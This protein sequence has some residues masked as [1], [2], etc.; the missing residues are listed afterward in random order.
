MNT[1]K[2]LNRAIDDIFESATQYWIGL[3]TTKPAVD[4]T[5]VTEPSGSGTGY[6]RVLLA[7]L[8]PAV[9]GVKTNTADIPFPESTA[10]WSESPLTHYVVFDNSTGG[11]LLFYGELVPQRVVEAE[12]VQ[13]IMK[14]G[15]VT[16]T[17]RNPVG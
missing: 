10:R 9:G 7:N 13:L 3:S 8:A 16:L 1:T 15:Q 17:L 4:G 11:D 6:A 5:N 2:F 12:G 14:A